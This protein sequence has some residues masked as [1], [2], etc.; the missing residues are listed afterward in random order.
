MGVLT[1]LARITYRSNW[2]FTEASKL[3]FQQWFSIGWSHCSPELLFNFF[4][5]IMFGLVPCV[6]K[7]KFRMEKKNCRP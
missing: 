6:Q 2:S 3:L 5:T 1:V 7:G 4:Y